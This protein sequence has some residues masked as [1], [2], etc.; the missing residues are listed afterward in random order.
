[1]VAD[2][3]DNGRIVSHRETGWLYPP[4]DTAKLAEGIDTLLARPDL[5]AAIGDAARRRVLTAH[6]WEATA[7]RVVEI[8][9]GIAARS[10]SEGSAS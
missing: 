9:R 8:A 5:A 2:L 7:S 6:T 3:G 4:G 10:A 1:V